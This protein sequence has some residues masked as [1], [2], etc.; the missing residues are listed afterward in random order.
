MGWWSHDVC[1]SSPPTQGF[2]QGWLVGAGHENQ[3]FAVWHNRL[4]AA[5]NRRQW[6]SF[7]WDEITGCQTSDAA[8]SLPESLFPSSTPR[9]A[10]PPSSIPGQDFLLP[11][12]PLPSLSGEDLSESI[13]SFKESPESHYSSSAVAHAPSSSTSQLSRERLPSL[14]P[15]TPP[16]SPKK[17]CLISL[18]NEL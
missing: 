7:K 2:A 12:L 10:P 9:P 11:P 4:F 6:A 17:V 3:K 13:Y 15:Q 14:P 5:K 8:A 16:T 1:P 18:P